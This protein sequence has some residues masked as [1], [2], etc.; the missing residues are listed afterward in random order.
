MLHPFSVP[1]AAAARKPSHVLNLDA[2]FRYALYPFVDK[3]ASCIKSRHDVAKGRTESDGNTDRSCSFRSHP[4]LRARARIISRFRIPSSGHL[5]PLLNRKILNMAGP[6]LRS[7]SIVAAESDPNL[8]AKA[9]PPQDETIGHSL[10]EVIFARPLSLETAIKC[11]PGGFPD[12]LFVLSL[13]GV[14]QHLGKDPRVP[15]YRRLARVLRDVRRLGYS[16]VLPKGT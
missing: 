6:C 8:G 5:Q 14:L 3:P 15:G 4:G 10:W 2:S 16:G 11:P 13:S 7:C 1:S 12:R 9:Q